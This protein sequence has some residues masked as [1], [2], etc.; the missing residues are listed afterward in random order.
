M[1]RAWKGGLLSVAYDRPIAFQTHLASLD[2]LCQ[3]HLTLVFLSSRPSSV[4]CSRID[5]SKVVDSSTVKT[6]KPIPIREPIVRNG[7]VVGYLS[8][9]LTLT[10]TGLTV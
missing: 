3:Q 6:G 2:V 7:L 1:E 10:T 4:C 9:T 8:A 5:L